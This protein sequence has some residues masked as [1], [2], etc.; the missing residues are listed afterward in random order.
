MNFIPFSSVRVWLLRGAG[1]SIGENCRLFRADWSSEPYL[2]RLGNHV[3][4][5]NNVR[6]LTHDGAVWV[7]RPEYPD[8]DV[9]GTIDVGNNVCIGI[10][11]IL[12]PNT[13]IGDNCIIGAGSVVKGNIPGNSVVFGNPA[14]VVMSLE[15]QK[16]LVL[17]S[18]FRFRS[19]R[20]TYR[21]K[22]NML[23]RYF[24][25]EKNG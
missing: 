14:K 10:N 12:L 8:L 20:M 5:S 6:F 21:K 4:V 15:M 2:I 11:A 23:L 19:K 25:F 16:K 3:V 22:K 9:F 1:V 17:M 13:R 18:R 24:K 7:F